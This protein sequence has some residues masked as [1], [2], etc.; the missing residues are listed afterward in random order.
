MTP[1]LDENGVQVQFTILD[2]LDLDRIWDEFLLDELE[3]LPA[4]EMRQLEEE[5][6]KAP[7]SVATAHKASQPRRWRNVSRLRR[8]QELHAL[9]GEVEALPTRLT[10]Q[11][12][13]HA[14]RG[15]HSSKRIARVTETNRNRQRRWQS[16][17][18]NHVERSVGD[19]KFGVTRPNSTVVRCFP[20]T[21]TVVRQEF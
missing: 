19:I 8:K 7:K 16:M 17:N 6:M 15:P 18:A 12:G 14:N 5:K 11:Q 21:T 10:F 1:R 9:R 3:R 2:E 20:D 13:R 4:E